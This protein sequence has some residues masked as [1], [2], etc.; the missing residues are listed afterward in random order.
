MQPP[1]VAH[2]T[3]VEDSNGRWRREGGEENGE[4]RERGKRMDKEMVEGGRAGGRGETGGGG[5]GGGGVRGSG[6]K[7]VTKVKSGATTRYRFAVTDPR[8]Y[9]RCFSHGA[10]REE[11]GDEEERTP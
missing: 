8:T 10:T 7:R 9:T 4:T 5:Y 3:R 6:G 2:A 11:L 1:A